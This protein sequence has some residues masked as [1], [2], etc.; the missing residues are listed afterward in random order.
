MYAFNIFLLIVFHL[1][2]EFV[3]LW[4][5]AVILLFGHECFTGKCCGINLSLEAIFFET[6][7]IFTLLCLVFIIIY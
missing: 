5:I 6:I 7:L 4:S 3:R 2:K 1:G